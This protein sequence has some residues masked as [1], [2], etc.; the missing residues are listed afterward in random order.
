[1]ICRV[2]SPWVTAADTSL[3]A[4]TC[5]VRL[6]ASRSTDSVRSRHVPRD[7]LD[8]GLAAEL[9]LGAHLAGDAGDLRRER[10]ELVDHAVDGVGERRDLA[11]GLDR[12]LLRQVAVGHRRGDV[13]DRAAPGSVRF[14]AMPFTFS[15]RSRHVPLDAFHLGLAAEVDLPGLPPRVRPRVTSPANEEGW[16]TIVL[17]VSFSSRISPNTSTVIFWLRSPR[18]TGRGSATWADVADLVGQVRRH[19]VHVVGEAASTCRSDALDLGLAAEATLGADL[20]EFDAG[21][22]VGEAGRSRSTIVLR[23]FFRVK[24]LAAHLD[25]DLGAA[26]RHGPLRWSRWRSSAPGRSGSTPCRSPTR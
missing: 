15:V 17:R 20:S 10:R 8:L 22:L 21:D 3:I 11:A 16:S 5:V 9:A 25:G 7:V 12:D 4:R 6:P 14:D 13:R 1:M 24:A 18:A 19:A 26:G 23:V 2:R